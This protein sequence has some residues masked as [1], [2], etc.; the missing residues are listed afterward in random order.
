MT[1]ESATWTISENENRKEKFMASTKKPRQMKVLHVSVNK[2]YGSIR[3]TVQGLTLP[4]MDKP[5]V[6]IFL[7]GEEYDLYAVMEERLA[8]SLR[9]ELN[10]NLKG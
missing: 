8:R 10:I 1:G 5:H 7:Q 9:E 4:A 2:G 6:I 3:P